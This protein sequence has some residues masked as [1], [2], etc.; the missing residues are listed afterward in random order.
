MTGNRTSKSLLAIGLA[1]A[2]LAAGCVQ[3]RIE[4]PN[5]SIVLAQGW[6]KGH[7][8]VRLAKRRSPPVF[9][10]RQVGFFTFFYPLPNAGLI[11]L[12]MG[13]FRRGVPGSINAAAIVTG[14]DVV[15]GLIGVLSYTFLASSSVRVYG[16][17]R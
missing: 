3:Y 17:V 7:Q 9:Q 2:F 13:S 8:A 12:N 6:D 16:N 4:S 1:V 10:T 15:D 5:T 11:P 14:H